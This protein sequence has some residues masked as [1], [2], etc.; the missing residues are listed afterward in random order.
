MFSLRADNI[1]DVVK[2]LHLCST[3]FGLTSFT[4]SDSSGKFLAVSTGFWNIFCIIFSSIWSLM[5]LGMFFSHHE[6]I[7]A[8]T[9]DYWSSKISARGFIC[10][11]VGFIFIFNLVN[12]WTFCNRKQFARLLSTVTEWDNDFEVMKH[13]HPSN[14][15]QHKRIVLIFI[16]LLTLLAI[17]SIV[18]T[19]YFN[20]THNLDMIHMI[21]SLASVILLQF[22]NFVIFHFIF[23]VWAVKLRYQK[24]NMYL[25]EALP[26]EEPNKKLNIAATL[27]DQLVDITELINQ[28]YGVPV[29]LCIY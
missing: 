6:D 24:I 11:F 12:W 1:Y 29:R 7:S 20:C 2:P 8:Q 25:D 15:V 22:I 28:C 23:W 10:I 18:S 27:H 17:H 21:C 9:S 4:V 3:I 14:Y 19:I 26:N 16:A 13:R 5:T